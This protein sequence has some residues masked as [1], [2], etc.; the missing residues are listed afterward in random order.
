MDNE[1]GT[2]P[3]WAPL[4]DQIWT[5]RVSRINA[6]RRLTRKESFIQGINIYYSCATS[7][8][9]I[10]SIVN[11]DDKLGLVAT[12][13]SI[14]VLVCILYLNAQKY[15]ERAKDFR[16]NYTEM[17]KLEMKLDTKNISENDLNEIK[18]RY[19]KLLYG[20]INHI[21]YDYYCTIYESHGAYREK[22]WSQIKHLFFFGKA[23]R[24][25]VMITLVL[26]PVFIYFLCG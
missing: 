3:I 1:K 25:A 10:L 8:F 21:P 11:G 6:E 2:D 13:M 16:H 14:V 15:L 17:H 22:Y 4:K 23:W 7:I 5:T 20:S 12:L 18:N 26:L 9:S 19:C 24:A